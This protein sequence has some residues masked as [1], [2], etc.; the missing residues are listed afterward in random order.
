VHRAASPGAQT[1]TID[2]VGP[3]AFRVVQIFR[4]IGR[5]WSWID[6]AGRVPPGRSSQTCA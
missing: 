3:A 2:V 5:G 4:P 6:G 1:R